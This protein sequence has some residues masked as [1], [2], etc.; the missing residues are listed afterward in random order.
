LFGETL[1]G[2]QMQMQG[3]GSTRAATTTSASSA[4]DG[5]ASDASGGSGSISQSELEQ[6]F[7]S[8]AD[9]LLT[10]LDQNGDDTIDPTETQ[11]ALTPRHHRHG[12]PA[13]ESASSGAGES[14]TGATT[15]SGAAT[16]LLAQELGQAA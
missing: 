1:A 12:R 16:L 2:L 5:L 14:N 7:T 3:Q 11:Q 13:T 4:T 15:A 9:Q 10:K 8:Q 6:A